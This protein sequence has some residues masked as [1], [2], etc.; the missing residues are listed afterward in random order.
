[1]TGIRLLWSSA[2][3]LD[4]NSTD[5]VPDDVTGYRSHQEKKA[6]EEVCYAQWNKLT[7]HTQKERLLFSHLPRRTLNPP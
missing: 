4:A 6:K 2:A 7:L 1:M 3:V 5:P